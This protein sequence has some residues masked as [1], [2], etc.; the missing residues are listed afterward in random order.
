MSPDDATSTEPAPVADAEEAETK[1]S[2]MDRLAFMS[3]GGDK[4]DKVPV[5]NKVPK[6]LRVLF[7]IILVVVV[8]VAVVA[9]SMLMGG[10]DKPDGGSGKTIQ[11]EKL[12][13]WTWGPGPMAQP[14]LDEG[15]SQ[16][17]SLAALIENN[18]TVLV[19][20]VEVTITWTDE[21]DTNL[22]PRQ[23]ENEPDTFQLEMNSSAN[24]SAMSDQ[25][26]NSH[27]QSMSITLT[28]DVG[29][30]D[31]SYLVLGNVSADMKLPDDVAVSDI[32]II[33]HMIEAGD[34]HSPPPEFVYVNDFGND[35][36]IDIMASGK[37]VPEDDSNPD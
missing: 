26:S 1:R 33:V 5:I 18:G 4:M 11:P 16:P 25:M 7:V 2:M 34:F 28:L 36:S 23:K 15:R 20:Q 13:D 3:K 31:Y 19:D 37:I 35:Y 32:N 17:F 21:P 8:V 30:S 27:G 29:T 6:S 9:A 10:E 14:L 12:E 22:G 24:V